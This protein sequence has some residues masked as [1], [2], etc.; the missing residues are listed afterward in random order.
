M[1][2]DV[3]DNAFVVDGAFVANLLDLSTADFQTLM[4]HGEITSVC[5]E[6]LNEHENQFRLSFFYRNRRARLSIN[7]LGTGPPKV[8]GQFWFTTIPEHGS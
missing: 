8:C 5:E 4:R 1:K 7:K 6:G 2:V 3:Q